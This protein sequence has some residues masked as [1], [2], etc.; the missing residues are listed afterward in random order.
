VPAS[1]EAAWTIADGIEGWLTPGQGRTLFEAAAAVPDGEAV[2]E[3]GSHRG[4]STILLASGLR[5]GAVLTAIDPF[6]DPRWGGG[7]ASLEVFE[8]NLAQAGVREQVRLVRGL[9]G[10]VAATWT[11]P[12]VG[13]VWIDGAHDRASV[14]ADIDGWG[15][16]LADGGA[17]LLHDAFS[18]IGTTEAVL[19]RLWWSRRYRYVGCVRTLVAFRKERRSVLQ[20]VGDAAR[21]SRRLAFFSRMLAIKIARRR[22]LQGLERRFM[23]EPNEPLI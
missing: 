4:K 5:E 22:D 9:S 8:A 13:L 23:R 12:P 14:L 2:I 17:M 19:Q 16:H 11:G 3:V 20:A 7:A 6:D 10:D 15:A 18:A 1:F 21:L